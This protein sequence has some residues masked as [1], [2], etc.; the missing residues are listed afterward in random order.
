MRRPFRTLWSYGD[1]EPT[2]APWAIMKRPVGTE[3][4]R[5]HGKI[6]ASRPNGTNHTSPRRNRGKHAIRNPM[7]PNGTLH[8]G[9]RKSIP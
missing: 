4:K 8:R 7:R 1:A 3:G 6:K 9:I 5:I 2:D